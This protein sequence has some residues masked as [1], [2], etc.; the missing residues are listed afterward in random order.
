MTYFCNFNDV[1]QSKVIMVDK[2]LTE[3]N[4][5][6]SKIPD[7]EI[8]LC[9][10]HVMKY[11]KKKVSELDCK[12]AEK[13][14]LGV[15]LQKLINSQNQEEYDK[16]HKE[17]EKFNTGFLQYFN[18]N[19]H[20]CQNLWV[21]HFRKKLRTHGNNTNN[22]IESHNQKLKKY[23]S[24]TMRLP[25]AIE[26]LSSFID[27]TYAKSSFNRY[28][29]LKTKI[30]QRN[31][32]GELI[33]FSFMC[34]PKAF[35]IVNDE[36]RILESV[37]FEIIE[38]SDETY[39]VIYKIKDSTF[40][41]SVAKSMNDCTCLCFSNFGLPCRHIFACRKKYIGTIFEENLIPNRWTMHMPDDSQQS[42][43]FQVFGLAS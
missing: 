35:Q 27:E 11:L 39:S 36:L 5:L 24:K 31:T 4:A 13:Q 15:L 16:L 25:E 10:F 26:N 40:N 29:N 6:K 38:E 19:W 20:S 28:A 1:S 23:V 8:L 3:I 30:D 41:V 2:D 22:K 12:N 37:K 18:K 21:M 7:A 14:E 9:K 34:N 17:L 32:D 33:K 42:R 43:V